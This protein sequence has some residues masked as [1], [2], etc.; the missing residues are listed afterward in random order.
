MRTRLSS[1]N[2]AIH[3]TL[4][5]IAIQNTPALLIGWHLMYE[6]CHL[7]PECVKYGERMAGA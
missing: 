3:A 7:V 5:A 6:W 2:R 1:W 4:V